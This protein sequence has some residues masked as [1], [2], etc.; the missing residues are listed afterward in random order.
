MLPCSGLS[1]RLG[2]AGLVFLSASNL[3]PTLWTWNLPPPAGETFAP[4]KLDPRRNDEPALSAFPPIISFPA[5]PAAPGLT[6]STTFSWRN[7]VA[8]LWLGGSAGLVCWLLNGFLTARRWIR[9][10]APPVDPAWQ[11]ILSAECQR[12]S[13]H[14]TP[15]LLVNPDVPGPCVTGCFRPALL[16]PACCQDWDT[17]T[18]I[19]VIRHELAH[20]RHRDAPHAWIRALTLTIHWLDPLVWLAISRSRHAEELAA[21]A[22]ILASGIR[23]DQYA[24]VLLRVAR[25]CQFTTQTPFVNAM[26]HSSNLESRIRQ[27]LGKKP[28]VRSPV[29]FAAAGICLTFVTAGFIGCST[30][31]QESRDPKDM[32]LPGARTPNISNDIT[33]LKKLFAAGPTKAKRRPAWKDLP[34]P[35]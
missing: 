9:E 10:A 31:Q 27:L 5:G 24:A 13:L 7:C 16:L 29:R 25:T 23:P 11:N 21:D 2:L 20:L 35:S 33:E 17:E 32:N 26:A 34:P 30:V 4:E 28:A 3:L 6:H 22:A 14:R 12:Q 15:R 1:W 18:R 8:F 19:L